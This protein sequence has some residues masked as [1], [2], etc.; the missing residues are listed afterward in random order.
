MDWWKWCSYYV[1]E[2]RYPYPMMQLL[3]F[4]AQ[5]IKMKIRPI[6]GG[7][8]FS[9]YWL[10]MDWW[11][12]CLLCG[13]GKISLPHDA[14]TKRPSAEHEHDNTSHSNTYEISRGPVIKRTGLMF[15]GMIH[16]TMLDFIVSKCPVSNTSHVKQRLAG[17]LGSWIYGTYPPGYCVVGSTALIRRQLQFKPMAAYSLDLTYPDI[18]SFTPIKTL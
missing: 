6:P 12:Q 13:W 4:P 9:P 16:P 18:T 10:E 3:N 2:G 17:L 8:Y 7:S 14:A 1:T 11:G 5:N 15:N